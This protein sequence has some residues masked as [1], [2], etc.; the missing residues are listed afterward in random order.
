MTLAYLTWNIDPVL[1]KIGSASVYWY[2]FFLALSFYI[3]FRLMMHIY[4]SE[5]KSKKTVLSYGLFILAGLLLGGRLMHCLAYEPEYYLKYPLDIIKPWRGDL[6]TNARFVGYR[7]MSGHGSAIGI[8]L[9]IVINAFRTRTS[10]VWMVDR[11]AIFGPLIGFF[12]R[13]GNFFNSEILGKPSNS[14][15]AVIF[16]RKDNIPR[17]PVQLY[18]AFTY[19]I[20]FI[21]SYAYYKKVAGNEK[22]GAILG[23]VLILVYTARF[24]LEFFKAKQSD[25]ES[26]LIMNMGH[27]LSIPFIIAGLVLYFRPQ[28]KYNTNANYRSA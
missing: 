22:P 17:H 12:V 15:L 24:L 28:K 1:F 3:S 2:S 25:I 19:L 23:L 27:L 20:I 16:A 5:N 6:G 4:E 10:L 9:G 21:I 14:Q 18:E 8:I 11:I 13:L 7:G 26:G